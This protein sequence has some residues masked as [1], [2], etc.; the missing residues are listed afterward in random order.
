M[1]ILT[2]TF[3]ITIISALSVFSGFDFASALEEASANN[4]SRK[5]HGRI[6]DLGWSGRIIFSVLFVAVMIV[7]SQLSKNLELL[8]IAAR[9]VLIFLIVLNIALRANGVRAFKVF[10]VLWLG[11]LISS[12][13]NTGFTVDDKNAQL[14]I[15]IQLVA[16]VLLCLGAMLG[17]LIHFY[18]N[19]E[20]ELESG[21]EPGPEEADEDAE[22]DSENGSKDGSKDGS[23]FLVTDKFIKWLKSNWEILIIIIVTITAII[24][25]T[26]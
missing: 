9:C 18:R 20:V 15:V 26:R 6:L 13:K 17:N 1:T 10:V 24:M 23:K 16:F 21:S 11:N 19:I 2:F 25:V 14:F 12:L 8:N 22:S 4:V 7:L 5:G 3:F